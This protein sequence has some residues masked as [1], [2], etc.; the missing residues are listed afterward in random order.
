MELP[1]IVSLNL[2]FPP[3]NQRNFTE[4]RRN[5][6]YTYC[7]EREIPINSSGLR[8][9]SFTFP[10]KVFHQTLAPLFCQSYIAQNKS[11]KILGIIF[12]T[13]H[14]RIIVYRAKQISQ[15]FRNNI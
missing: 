2:T 1:L 11:K 5:T 3:K 6:R 15:N 9:P 8:E 14:H 4:N 7:F 10:S 12:G 13:L